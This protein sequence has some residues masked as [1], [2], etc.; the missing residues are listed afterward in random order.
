[1][2]GDFAFGTL[3]KWKKNTIQKYYLFYLI[4]AEMILYPSN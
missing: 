1:M 3:L 2:N 4:D